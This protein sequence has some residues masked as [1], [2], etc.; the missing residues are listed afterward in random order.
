R[1]AT[2]SGP[3]QCPG[4][5]GLGGPPAAG[6]RDEADRTTVVRTGV[7]VALAGKGLVVVDLEDNGQNPPN[8]VEIAVLPIADTVAAVDAMTWRGRPGR[9]ITP[10]AAAAH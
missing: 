1:P 6:Q 9:A 7:P 8:I 10:E 3:G 4:P 2:P 5:R